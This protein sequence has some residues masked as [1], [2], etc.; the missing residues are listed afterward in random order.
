MSGDVTVVDDTWR[1]TD[2]VLAAIDI[3]TNSVHMI[4]ARVDRQGRLDVIGKEK[5]MVRLGSG[6]GDMKC[7]EPDAIDRGVATLA[8]MSEIATSR[9][10]RVAAVA[11]SAVREAENRLDFID[12][13]WTEAGLHVEVVSGFEEAR[14]IH[15]GVRNAVPLGDTQTLL[16]DIGGGSTELVVAAGSEVLASRSLRLGAIRLT[17][18]FFDAEPL[19]PEA[20]DECR[21]HIRSALLPFATEVRRLGFET[22]VGSSGTIECLAAV[23]AAAHGVEPRTFNNFVVTRDDITTVVEAL[24]DAPTAR[25]RG[26]IAGV[27]ARRADIIVAGALILEQVVA[28]FAIDEIVVSEDALREGVLLDFASRLDGASRH[29]LHDLRRQSVLHLVE[30][31]DDDAQHS[32]HVA[33]LSLELFDETVDLHGLGEVER[34]LLEAGALLA[35]VGVAISHSGHHKHSYY[36]IRNSE[37]LTGFTDHEIELI[38]LIARY[39]RKSQPKPKH[40]EFAALAPDDQRKVEV[41]A[42]LLRIAI[43]LDRHHA[44]RVN[45]IRADLE[46]NR[47][48]IG[49]VADVTEDIDLELFAATERRGLLESALGHPVLVRSDAAP[50]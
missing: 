9:G 23:A 16:C 34:E 4:V 50:A 47:L 29:H 27:E 25:K 40:I 10:A 12:R 8:R 13:A 1:V 2:D 28:E 3:G 17:R 22:A 41:L 49:A 18:R 35:N 31:M 38:A 30:L 24:L 19:D 36:V 26:A 46:K 32:A 33:H 45:G 21:R 7:L 42:G 43:G 14:L 48:V 39:H 5:E 37:H 11:T 44:G 20:V 15:V 6:G